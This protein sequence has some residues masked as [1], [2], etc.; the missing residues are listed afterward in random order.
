MGNLQWFRLGPPRGGT[1]RAALVLIIK[2]DEQEGL[3][4]QAL[5][6]IEPN[7]LESAVLCIQN[8]RTLCK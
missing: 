8:L 2:A 6:Y 4:I 7:Q 5:E 3:H 1:S